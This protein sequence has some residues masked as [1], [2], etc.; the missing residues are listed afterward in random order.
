MSLGQYLQVFSICD[1]SMGF[2]A[3]QTEPLLEVTRS[4]AI[5]EDCKLPF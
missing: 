2:Q 1:S 4:R 3:L 5:A